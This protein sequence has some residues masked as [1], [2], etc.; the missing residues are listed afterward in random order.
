[1][2][3]ICFAFYVYN[4]R[5]IYRLAVV[6]ALF[7]ILVSSTTNELFTSILFNING[8]LHFLQIV[9]YLNQDAL[10]NIV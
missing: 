8:N 2:Y 4:F 5:G 10:F 3:A 9:V 7:M 1:M 6:G